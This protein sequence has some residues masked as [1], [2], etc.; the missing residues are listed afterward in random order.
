[1]PVTTRSQYRL[2]N[3]ICSEESELPIQSRWTSLLAAVHQVRRKKEEEQEEQE[4]QDWMERITNDP[5]EPPVK[6][7]SEDV[8]VAQWMAWI[9]RK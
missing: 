4:R 1:M 3:Q 6:D 7:E 2:M 5:V 8:Q 9:S